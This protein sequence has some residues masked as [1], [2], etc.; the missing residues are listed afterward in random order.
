MEQAGDS[1]ASLT[2]VEACTVRGVQARHWM[3]AHLHFDGFT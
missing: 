2:G 1:V 3:S